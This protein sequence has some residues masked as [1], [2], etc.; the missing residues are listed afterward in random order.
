[1]DYRHLGKSDLRVSAIGLGSWQYGSEGWGFG[2]DFQERDAVKTVERALE[3]GINFIDTAE[4]YGSGRSEEIVGKTLRGR[5]EELVIATKVSRRHLRYQDVLAAAEG[6]LKRLGIQEIDLYQIHWP[7]QYVPLKE[8]M[9]ALEELVEAGKVRYLGLS[10]FPVSLMQEAASHL[11]KAELV[12]NQVK[13]NLLQRDVEAEVLPYCRRQGMSVI[14]YSPI[15]KGL[16]T[17]KYSKTNVPEDMVR[18]RDPLFSNPENLEACLG[19]VDVLRAIASSRGKTV[20]QVALNW[21]TRDLGVVAIVGAKR[22]G[23]IEENVGAVGWE[24]S[25]EELERID[26]A[27][28]GLQLSYF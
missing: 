4:V 15:A 12:S 11:N 2:V 9:R 25:D 26:Q 3:L 5:R 17:G 18:G 10:N 8:T 7:N 14:A 6:S 27:V 19:V 28:S 20:V 22:P 21:I 24:L 16:L 13:Y 1:M 23:Q